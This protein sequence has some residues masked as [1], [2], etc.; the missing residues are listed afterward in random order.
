MKQLGA[1]IIV[2]FLLS[3]FLWTI[4]AYLRPLVNRIGR[5]QDERDRYE[6]DYNR[7]VHAVAEKPVTFENFLF[8]LGQFDNISQYRCLNYE[9]LQVLEQQFYSK[10]KQFKDEKDSVHYVPVSDGGYSVM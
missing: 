3:V 10:F 2:V 6:R 7:L 5:R 4:F 8:L 1:F 9:K